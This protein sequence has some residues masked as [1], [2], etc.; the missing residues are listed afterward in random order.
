MIAVV[1]SGSRFADWRL[2]E[3]GKVVAGFKTMG[4]NPYHNDER[5]ISQ[6][7]NKNNSLIN[8]AERIKKIFF[9]ALGRPLT[10]ENRLFT[11][12]SKISLDIVKYS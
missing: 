7:L 3:R 12:L 8:Y 5:Y 9:L 1:Y 6:I 4:I 2:A 10:I 11:M